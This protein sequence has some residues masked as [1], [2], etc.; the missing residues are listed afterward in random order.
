MNF[1]RLSASPFA[2][3]YNIS[4]MSASKFVQALLLFAEGHLIFLDNTPCVILTIYNNKNT[5]QEYVQDQINRIRNSV[6]DRQ[7]QL[8][9]WIVNE[10]SKGKRTS[11]AKVK[12]SCQEKPIRK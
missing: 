11:R 7:S 9:R 1:N 6:E 12:N 3:D 5:Q 4:H 2:L 8:A 10:I